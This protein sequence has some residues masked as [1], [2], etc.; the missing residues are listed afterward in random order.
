MSWEEIVVKEESLENNVD[1]V[2]NEKFVSNNIQISKKETDDTLES[3]NQP[4][5]NVT[6]FKCNRCSMTFDNVQDK[7]QHIK[8]GLGKLGNRLFQCPKCEFRS[9]YFKGATEHLANNHAAAK[10]QEEKNQ[11]ENIS[12]TLVKNPSLYKCDRCSMNFDNVEAKNQHMKMG[13]GKL[14]LFQCPECEF[15]S[16]HINGTKEHFAEN[17]VSKIQE[18]KNQQENIQNDGRTNVTLFKC[19]HCS[20]TFDN[21]DAKDQHMKMG[22]GKLQLFKCPE[23]EFRSCHYNGAKEHYDQNHAMKIQE[24]KNQQENIT[25]NVTLFKCDHCRQYFDNIDD[26]EQHMKM[27][28]GKLQLFKCPECEFQSCHYN[29]AMEH[30]TQNHPMKIQDDE[31]QH[32]ENMQNA[33]NNVTMYRCD[34][35]SMTFDNFEAKDQHV[36]MGV[37]K[38]NQFQCPECEFRSCHYDEAAEHYAQNHGTKIQENDK[39]Q[40]QNDIIYGREQEQKI[41]TPVS[42]LHQKVVEALPRVTNEPQKVLSKKASLREK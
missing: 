25:N 42:K 32:E 37:G 14:Q 9:C 33:T 2:N 21:N 1:N 34:R 10:I 22:N 28:N 30:Y 41:E 18:D 35:C 27:G 31:N 36:K 38:L 40:Q 11:Q 6:F 7:D 20:T 26:K 5:T 8:M 24:D 15:R 13:L 17:H 3:E 12:K 29:G 39:S 19:D 23:C 4:V 16:C